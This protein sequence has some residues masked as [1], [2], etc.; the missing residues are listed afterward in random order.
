MEERQNQP[1]A[2]IDIWKD[3]LL[4][5]HMNHYWFEM[6]FGGKLYLDYNDPSNLDM[7]GYLKK[8][9]LRFAHAHEISMNLSIFF[10][11]KPSR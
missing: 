4:I 3:Y 8:K 9:Y 10:Y 1:A 11:R 2:L 7:K 6:T 5:Y